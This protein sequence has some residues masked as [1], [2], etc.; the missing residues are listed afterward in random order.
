MTIEQTQERIPRRRLR[1]WPGVVTVVLQWLPWLVV[2]FVPG[3]A[4]YAVMA[5]ALG[6]VL[7]I[8]WWLFF[9]RAPWLER[10]GALVLMPIAVLAAKRVVHPSIENGHMGMMLPL[11]SIPVLSLALVAWAVASHRL[12]SGPRRAAM[13]ASILLSCGAFTLLRTGGISGEG[14]SDIHWR[15]TPTPEERLL[16]QAGAEP[17]VASPPAT[18]APASSPAP[19]AGD[20]EASPWLRQPRRFPTSGPRSGPAT[21]WRRP[22]LSHERRGEPIGPASAGP[23]ATASFAACGSRPTGR[24]RRRSRCGAGRSDQAGRPSPSTATASTPWVRPV[25]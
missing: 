9:S 17:A 24:R 6:G 10:A 20:V 15:W 21:S 16:S 18:R 19:A 11:Y 5:G 12:S 22:R 3:S 1:L 4:M 8:A 25:S 2:P 23:T 7:I 13:V 14:A